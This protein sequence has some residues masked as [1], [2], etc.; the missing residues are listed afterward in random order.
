MPSSIPSGA[1]FGVGEYGTDVYGVSNITVIPDGVVG[2]G[3]IPNGSFYANPAAIFGVTTYGEK[4]LVQGDSNQLV[5]GVEALSFI[6]VISVTGDSIFLLPSVEATGSIGTVTQVTVNRVPV[7]GVVGTTELGTITL[8][9]NNY[10]DVNSVVANGQVGNIVV[11]A[12]AA[13]S[14]TGV[15]ATGFI[16]DNLTILENEVVIPPSAVGTGI[17]GTPVI[18]TVIFDFNTVANLYDRAR[19]VYV[20]RKPSVQERT[21]IV[22]RRTTSKER[23]V[24]VPAS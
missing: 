4:V 12:K 24:L 8:E 10:L 9:T 2:K 6:G 14:V 13:V 20:F 7:T 16:N 15:F 22:P 23:T 5:T 1:V 21:V 18:T 17:I 3:G 19:V 11:V